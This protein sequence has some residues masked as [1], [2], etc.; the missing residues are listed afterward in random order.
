[1]ARVRTTRAMSCAGPVASLTITRKTVDRSGHRTRSG[2]ETEE[3]ARATERKARAKA[4]AKAALRIG[5][6]VCQKH[7]RMVTKML[8]DGFGVVSKLK[9]GGKGQM[10]R[11]VIGVQGQWMSANDQTAWEPEGPVGGIEMNS[12]ETKYI[13]QDQLGQECLRLNYDSG[14]AVMALPVAVAGDLPLEKRGEFRV[15]S[16]AVIQIWARS[17]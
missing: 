6:K 15:A 2:W 13:K 4:R 7:L 10:I 3:T 11:N 16:G 1:M 12:I 14:A 5:K 8:M 9:D 17:K